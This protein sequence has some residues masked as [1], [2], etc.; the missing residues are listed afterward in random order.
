MN[1]ELSLL[2][3]KDVQNNVW[4]S[5][6]GKGMKS[7]SENRRKGISREEAIEVNSL[8]RSRRPGSQK[9]I[10]GGSEDLREKEE[11]KRLVNENP[12]T[13]GRKITIA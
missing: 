2:R 1:R 6:S 12:W 10:E 11:L 4:K 3:V 5:N 7:D 13:A 8:M 9:E